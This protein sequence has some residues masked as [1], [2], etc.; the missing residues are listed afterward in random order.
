MHTFTIAASGT[1][2]DTWACLQAAQSVNDAIASLDAAGAALIGLTTDTEW[3]ADG[4][5]ALNM[6]LESFQT[7][8]STETGRLQ[9]RVHEIERAA[10]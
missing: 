2:V 4:V 5:R 3:S 10:S 8:A 6:K 9:T 7:R 1:S